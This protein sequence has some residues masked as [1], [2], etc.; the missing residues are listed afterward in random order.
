MSWCRGSIPSPP[1]EFHVK[2]ADC[3]LK[4][5]A[6]DKAYSQMDEYLKAE[7]DGRFAAKIKEI[8]QRMKAAGVLGQPQ[9]AK[10]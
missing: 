2:M 9:A 6:F 10:Q 5:K 1:A 4:E 7:P 8:M 3:Y